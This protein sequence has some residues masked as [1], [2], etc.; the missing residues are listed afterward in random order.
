MSSSIRRRVQPPPTT[1]YNDNGSSSI[2]PTIHQ[3][4]A[5]SKNNNWNSTSTSYHRSTGA[6]IVF[7][8]ISI[9]F[10]CLVVS[11]LRFNKV[12]V[13]EKNHNAS[14][15]SSSSLIKISASDYANITKFM[16]CINDVIP[17]I[18][19]IEH[20]LPGYRKKNRFPKYTT[21][22][23]SP[24]NKQLCFRGVYDGYSDL[25]RDGIETR[26]K[27]IALIL[28]SLI[29]QPDV[30]LSPEITT[31]LDD[32]VEPN[33]L[34]RSVKRNKNYTRV[35]TDLHNYGGIHADYFES[36]DYVYTSIL[37][38]NPSHDLIGGQTALV[39]F[40]ISNDD[41]EPSPNNMSF[42]MKVKA[43]NRKAAVRIE[44]GNAST[45]TAKKDKDSRPQID[46]TS[47]MI[48]G[49][50]ITLGQIIL[51]MWCAN[52][53]PFILTPNV[54]IEPKHGRLVL[55]T[56]GG[57]N[58]HAPMQVIRGIRPTHHIWYRCKQSN[59]KSVVT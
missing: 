30:Q 5:V 20:I 52:D 6:K 47:G 1:D 32:T 56:A 12:V 13:K 11:I 18:A 14:S 22:P 9:S 31:Q 46:F 37:Y 38:D 51:S 36:S 35:E 55:F 7:C 49:K 21:L 34:E 44:K 33:I 59:R 10:S 53:I 29:L 3:D 39:D 28:E 24:P 48:V 17:N 15:S 42:G 2:L 40:I 16:P 8:F 45:K 23:C 41:E 4:S 54:F 57:E 58:F 50:F 43:Q 25:L 26:E 27:K 19:E